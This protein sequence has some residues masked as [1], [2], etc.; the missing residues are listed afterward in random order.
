MHTLL[1]TITSVREVE[2]FLKIDMILE[3]L[4]VGVKV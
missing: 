2:Q 3:G 4:S 1:D